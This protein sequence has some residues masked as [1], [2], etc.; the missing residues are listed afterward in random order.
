MFVRSVVFMSL[1]AQL[2]PAL[3]GF[4][5][6]DHRKFRDAAANVELTLD[7]GF[8]T[9]FGV[10]LG[11]AIRH[12]AAHQMRAMFKEY[13]ASP[14]CIPR[15]ERSNSFEPTCHFELALHRRYSDENKGIVSVAGQVAWC[16]SLII[17]AERDPER[18]CRLRDEMACAAL[19]IV[20]Q[21]SVGPCTGPACNRTGA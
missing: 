19:P 11:D 1:G 3:L 20:P 17:S 18:R 16:E 9:T 12:L 6:E 10:H 8:K 21:R 5:S 4:E 13:A 15:G 7:D 14:L 2:M